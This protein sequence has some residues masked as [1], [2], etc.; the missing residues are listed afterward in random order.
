MNVK[1]MYSFLA[2]IVLFLIALRGNGSRGPAVVFRGLDPLLPPCW[3]LSSALA[4][5]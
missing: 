5:G 4:G 3:S 2:V 1:Y